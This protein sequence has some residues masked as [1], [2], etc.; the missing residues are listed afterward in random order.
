MSVVVRLVVLL[1]ALAALAGL[2]LVRRRAA[3]AAVATVTAGLGVLL[4]V[5][6]VVG[7]DRGAVPTQVGTIGGLAAGDLTVPLT[8]LLDRPTA[9]VALAVTLVGLAVQVFSVWYLADDPRYAV[10]AAEVSLFLAGMLLVVHSG[11]LLLTLVGWEVMGWCSWL[12]IGHTSARESARRA[13]HKAFLVTRLADVGFVLGTVALAHSFGTTRIAGL[14]G[15]RGWFSS[16]GVPTQTDLMA[17]TPLLTLGLVGLVVGV[18]GKSGLVP[19]HDWLPDAMEG[20]TP[21][22]ALIHAATM[23][24]A[25][26]VVLARLEPLLAADTAARTLLGVLAAVT[27]VYAAALALAQ[28]D[29]KRLLAYSTLSQVAIML[30]A[31]AVVPESGPSS[32]ADAGL[33]QLVS[34]AL[35]K[36]LLFLA[37][38][39]LSV[40][41]GGTAVAVLR[42]RARGRGAL[43]WSLAIGLASL[44]GVPPLV[45]FLAKDG[46][47]TVVERSLGDGPTAWLLLV[48]LLVTVVLTAAYST[49]AWLLLTTEPSLAALEAAEGQAEDPEPAAPAGDEGPTGEHEARPVTLP[50]A[51]TVSALAVLTV[52]GGLLLLGFEW[53]WQLGWMTA[54][55]SVVLVVGTVVLVHRRGAGGADPA[56]VL[57]PRL[58]VAAE[59]GLGVDRAY[60][61]VGRAVTALA[62]GVV[63][64]DRVALDAYP[65][66]L[67]RAAGTVGRSAAARHRGT[68]STALVAVVTGVVVLAAL[69]VTLWS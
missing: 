38:G 12:L 66:L 39:W 8:L 43:Q 61:G 56:D 33:E 48:A 69:G 29:L 2:L 63:R 49:R 6:E 31:L 9:L 25:G 50:A 41:A 4:A 62:H 46:V 47:V 55:L 34:H 17:Q 10:F 16:G 51:L 20:P 53:G 64:V 37:I 30:A 19:F 5:A 32:A 40:L 13:A 23:V 27:M 44:A 11:D 14:L 65:R 18:A 3:A 59:D 42:G 28:A 52:L 26:T 57:P 60:A 67:A 58:R 24:A 7:T 22:S 45:G 35:F 36:S 15:E 54:V 21:A 68:P 1:P